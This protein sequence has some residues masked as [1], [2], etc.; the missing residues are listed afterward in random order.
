MDTNHQSEYD[1]G[2][3]EQIHLIDYWK[4]VRKRLSLA[5]T[6]FCVVVAS[7]L[8]YLLTATP[9]FEAHSRI[10]IT[11]DQSRSVM[12]SELSQSMFNDQLRFETELQ[13]LGGDPIYED[14]LTSLRLT[15]SSKGTEEYQ[16]ILNSLK[17]SVNCTRLRN[18][19]LLAIEASSA[20]SDTAALLVN[21]VVDVYINQ[22]RSRNLES[23]RSTAS[24][25]NDQLIDLEYKLKDSQQKLLDYI[26][27]EK[28]TFVS[29]GTGLESELKS[30]LFSAPDETLLEDLHTRL[31]QAKLSRDELLQ[32]YRDKHERVLAAVANV[33]ALER[34]YEA[35]KVRLESERGVLVD[36]IIEARRKGVQYDILKR[37]V[38]TNKELYN[39][40]IKKM[41]E[42]D[43]SESVGE[44][45]IKVVEAASA[46]I[47]PA[48]PKK[49][50]VLLIGLMLGVF[51]GVGSTFA[52]E[53]MDRSL[54]SKEEIES[55]TGLPVLASV[56]TID[57]IAT[58]RD[59]AFSHEVDWNDYFSNK[60]YRKEQELFRV[61]RTNIKFSDL[62]D[63]AKVILVTSGSPGEGKT[64]VASRLAVNMSSAGERVL[65]MDCDLR[66]PMVHKIF[67]LKNQMGV[68]NLIVADQYDS[69][70]FH[71]NVV[72][73]FDVITCGPIPAQPAELIENSRIKDVLSQLCGEY[74]RIIIDS[75]PVATV[76]DAALLATFADGVLLVVDPGSS[77]RRILKQAQGQLEKVGAKILGLVL[78]KISEDK[79]GYYYYY[80]YYHN[81]DYYGQDDG[82]GGDGGE[83]K[84][85][86]RRKRSKAA[87]V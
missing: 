61:L 60:A 75:P 68:T 69:Q 67:D 43:L 22:Y 53:Y 7:T 3:F 9:I 23:S 55:L 17:N 12:N 65:L 42:V 1:D 16:Q 59:A 25:L 37:Q 70:L 82:E 62:K 81:S 66:K 38:D 80:S 27:L 8:V 26:S 77:D 21:A 74:D 52:A 13:I 35:E 83:T 19:R 76:I 10:L 32:R 44:G 72:K 36:K 6:V 49:K 11:E 84:S 33:A 64:T 34:E 48:R 51:L 54:K 5:V 86:T 41:Q 73:N 87:T 14:V 40:F 46:P 39:L 20:S 29:D 79:E 24:W 63:K 28:I 56:N 4:I 30:D 47:F 45:D 15:S 2:L 85:K 50:L 58:Q 18:T 78:N 71:F 31:I 57:D